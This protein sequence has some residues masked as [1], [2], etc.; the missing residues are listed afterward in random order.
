M[1]RALWRILPGPKVVK[2][3]I[4]LALLAGVIYLLFQYVYPWLMYETSFFDNTVG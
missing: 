2:A 1:Y 4:A 3:L